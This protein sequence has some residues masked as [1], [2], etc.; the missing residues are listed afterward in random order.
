MSPEQATRYEDVDARSDI[1]SLGA[2]AYF[3][4]TGAPPFRGKNVIEVL[5][6]HTK[7]DVVP[8]SQK[9]PAIP[10]DVEQIVLRCLE[11]QPEER[12]QDVTSL[13]AALTACQC[14]GE[15]KQTDAAD[16]WLEHGNIGN[17]DSA[18]NAAAE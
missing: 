12:F 15:W 11:K 7:Q 8:P 10:S 1:S 5:A 18:S 9:G 2:V 13:T 16:W 14:S 6:A 3:M 4:L 17:A